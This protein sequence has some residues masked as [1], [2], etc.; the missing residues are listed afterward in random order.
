MRR[1]AGDRDSL[2]SVVVVRVAQ[3]LVTGSYRYARSCN[4]CMYGCMAGRSVR[5][6]WW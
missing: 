3:R 4:V 6:R 2:E 1:L 5:V